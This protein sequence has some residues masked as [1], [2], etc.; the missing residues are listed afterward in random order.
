MNEGDEIGEQ[1]FAIA[2]VFAHE[3][4]VGLAVHLGIGDELF[5]ILFDDQGTAD[6]V[7]SHFLIAKRVP[8][9]GEQKFIL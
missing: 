2:A 6:R 3:G 5:Q 4:F 1:L 8:E 9:K 7:G